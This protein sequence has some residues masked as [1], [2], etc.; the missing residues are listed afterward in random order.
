[1]SDDDKLDIEEMAQ[2]IGLAAH[3][4][5][6]NSKCYREAVA[7]K[8][9]DPNIQGAAADLYF[10]LRAIMETHGPGTLGP[11]WIYE[12][13][14]LALARAEGRDIWEFINANKDQGL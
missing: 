1:M 6:R 7:I 2:A 3:R 13:A 8:N 10:A 5:V 11:D 4:N 12:D 9:L 14:C